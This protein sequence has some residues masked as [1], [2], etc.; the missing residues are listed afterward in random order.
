MDGDAFLFMML[1]WG[2][3]LSLNIFCFTLLFSRGE[4]TGPVPVE[5]PTRE[6][7]EEE[8]EIT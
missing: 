8:D 1:S 2:F 4:R 6:I 5:K 7:V 3:I